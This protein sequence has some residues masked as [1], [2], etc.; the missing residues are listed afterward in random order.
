[1]FDREFILNCLEEKDLSKIES[2]FDQAYDLKVK[3]IGDKVYLRGIVE[4]SNICAKNCLYCG[5]RRDNHNRSLYELDEDVVLQG[6]KFALDSNYG[7]M[8]IQGGERTDAKFIAKITSILK[9]IKKLSEGTAKQPLGITL[10][11]GEQSLDVFEEWFEAGAHRYL[12]RIESYNEELYYKIHPRDSVHSFDRRV[13]ALYDLKTAGYQVGTGVMIGLPFQ[14]NDILCDDL[15]FFKNLDID[16][17]GMGPYLEHSDTP[18][19]QYRHLLMPQKERLLL[20]LKMVALLRMLMPDINIA[21]TTA[22]QVIDPFGRERAVK[23][24]ANIIMPNV[25]IADVRSDYQIYENKP[26]VEDD[27]VV[28]K[29]KLEENLEKMKIPIGWSQ[30]GDSLHFNKNLL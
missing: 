8:V 17:C 6:A 10:S 18:L 22:L 11:L 3:T 12:L 26:G 21:A 15:L 24:G 19:Y 23:A 25:T 1:M 27:A 2:L 13:Q 16:M 20:S 9:K 5:V 28:S 7:S 14:N 4:I 30:W 29:S